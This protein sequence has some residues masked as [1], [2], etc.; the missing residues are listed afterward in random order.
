MDKTEQMQKKISVGSKILVHCP[1]CQKIDY[2]IVTEDHLKTINQSG[3]A[4]VALDHGDH[5]CL[6]TFDQWGSIRG[7]YVYNKARKQKN[8][9]GLTELKKTVY[10]ETPFEELILYFFEY[11]TNTLEA[12]GQSEPEIER[13]I[14]KLIQI[15]TKIEK[16]LKV[17]YSIQKMKKGNTELI[18]GF[19]KTGILIL[20]SKKPLDADIDLKLTDWVLHAIQKL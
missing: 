8:N 13:D 6:V 19:G 17:K 14:I 3:I 11:A 2:F 7:T 16:S 18:F 4:Q 10:E 12:Y 9:F 15:S 20:V 1:K 5:V